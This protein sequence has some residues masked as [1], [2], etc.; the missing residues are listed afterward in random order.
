MSCSCVERGPKARGTGRH[1]N[2]YDSLSLHSLL[3][4]SGNHHTPPEWTPCTHLG[5]PAVPARRTDSKLCR[6][7]T[8]V[9]ELSRKRQ[10]PKGKMLLPANERQPSSDVGGWPSSP[11]WLGR[12][13]SHFLGCHNVKGAIK[14][15]LQ[16]PAAPKGRGC[17][18]TWHCQK[19]GHH[20]LSIHLHPAGG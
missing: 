4:P 14:P 2:Y 19:T 15:P 6:T 9:R 18:T 16:I 5:V 3:A 20:S 13:L 11:L 17:L 7:S 1:T 10:K 12:L 8:E